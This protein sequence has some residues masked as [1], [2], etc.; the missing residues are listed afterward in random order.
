M[1]DKPYYI[2]IWTR[3]I[4]RI[5]ADE[6]LVFNFYAY[7]SFSVI[8][9]KGFFCLLV[10]FLTNRVCYI[11]YFCNIVISYLH[12]FYK[13]FPISRYFYFDFI[14]LFKHFTLIFNC[15]KIFVFNLFKVCFFLLRRFDS[16]K[17]KNLGRILENKK[18]NILNC[19]K[20]FV[21]NY[22]FELFQLK[23]GKNWQMRV[24]KEKNAKK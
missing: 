14:F 23:K 21:L 10:K 3:Q 24:F 15:T 22:L 1:V 18:S 6:N 9:V 17:L 8:R 11:L 12:V 2:T 20:L 5:S 13:L 7:W 19:K 4:I 16:E